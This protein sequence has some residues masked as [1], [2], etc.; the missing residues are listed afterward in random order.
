LFHPLLIRMSGNAR[1][2]DAAAFQV[3]EEQHV[4]VASPR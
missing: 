4:V 3:K 2:G 1:H